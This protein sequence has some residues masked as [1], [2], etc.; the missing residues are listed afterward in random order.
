MGRHNVR[1]YTRSDGTSVSGHPRVG[2]SNGES[3]VPEAQVGHARSAAFAS[4]S[5]NGSSRAGVVPAAE[6]I[7]QHLTPEA[8]KFCDEHLERA[9]AKAE[10]SKFAIDKFDERIDDYSTDGLLGLLN[11]AA[12]DDKDMNDL[13]GEIEDSSE[14]FS[15]SSK[16]FEEMDSRIDEYYR[17]QAQFRVS[18]DCTDYRNAEHRAWGIV[19]EELAAAIGEHSLITRDG[20][21]WNLRCVN[22]DCDCGL[23][24]WEC[25]QD[26]LRRRSGQPASV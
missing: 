22:N 11:A 9:A 13:A 19:H 2:S 3:P 8:Q 1:P 20:D 26:L 25:M 12:G 15:D 21:S 4:Q 10:V 14:R 7:K 17:E 16:Q 23:D 24:E 6:A 18:G 5:G